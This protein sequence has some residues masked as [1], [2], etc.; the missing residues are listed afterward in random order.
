[1]APSSSS[2]AVRRRGPVITA[3]L[4]G[5]IDHAARPELTGALEGL[6]IGPGDL[7][8]LDLSG[9]T[10]LDSGGIHWLLRVAGEARATGAKLKIVEPSRVV[11]R[12]LQLTNLDAVLDVTAGSSS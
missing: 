11:L 4:A 6:R 12:L 5:E 8:L 3:T 2:F 10:F 1:M 7:V 9:V